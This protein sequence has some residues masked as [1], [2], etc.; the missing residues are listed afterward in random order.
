M[1]FYKYDRA[2]LVLFSSSLDERVPKSDKSRFIVQLVSQLN[3]DELYARY[4]NQGNDAY[5]PDMMLALWFY[6]Y[7][8]GVSS[9]RVLEDLCSYDARYIYISADL[10]PDHSTLSR[11]RKANLDLLQEYF[12]Q[13]IELSQQTKLSDFTDVNIDSTKLKA[14][15]S[16]K[17][18]TDSD[19]L[20]RKLNTIRA[21]I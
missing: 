3:L 6:A 17:L 18:S 2:Q 20:S 5:P 10:K 9:T 15:A 14:S 1:A 8:N 11:F 4:S 12:V 7:S 13:L 16:K 21:E 19:G